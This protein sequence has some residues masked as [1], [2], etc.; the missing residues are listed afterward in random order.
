MIYYRKISLKDLFLENPICFRTL[1]NRNTYVFFLNQTNLNNSYKQMSYHELSFSDD[2]TVE[3]L[4][5]TCG[6]Q[7]RPFHKIIKKTGNEIDDQCPIVSI[8]C[9]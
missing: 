3:I 2:A 6:I 8:G 1:V 4:K 7:L 5:R 9:L